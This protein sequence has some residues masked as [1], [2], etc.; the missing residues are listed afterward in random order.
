MHV[1]QERKKKIPLKII[2]V[3]ER[4]VNLD[5]EKEFR[6]LLRETAHFSKKRSNLMTQPGEIH[7]HA[8]SEKH[9]SPV[10]ISAAHVLLKP[11]KQE[12]E[13]KE[14]KWFESREKVINVKLQVKY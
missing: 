12:Q 7:E 14:F 9:L 11:L 13:W 6:V 1:K 2:L 10:I 5:D 4:Q 8:A 3:T